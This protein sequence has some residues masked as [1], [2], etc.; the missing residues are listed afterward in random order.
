MIHVE[1]VRRDKGAE[2][3]EEAE[4]GNGLFQVVIVTYGKCLY[5]ISAD[6]IIAEKGD[7][8]LIPDNAFFYGKSIPTVT[9]DKYTA[10]FTLA[11]G[12]DRS[13]LPMLGAER[14]L[15]LKPHQISLMAQR[16]KE[17]H[18]RW[19]EPF[20]YREALC[21]GILLEMLALLQAEWDGRDR[22][23]AKSELAEL[24]KSYIHNHYREKVTKHEIGAFIGKSPNYA[25]SLFR[26]MTGQTIGDYVHTA[27]V[28]AAQSLLVES[29]MTVEDISE[30][31]G[32]ADV[33]YFY[34]IFKMKLGQV[35]S[36]YTKRREA[37][38]L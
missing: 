34:R 15:L 6:K 23:S 9:H 2:W 29:G 4:P 16:F 24:M 11:A 31:V 1:Y 33:S 27:R 35:P 38:K 26:E 10:G 18:E 30:Y 21:A 32:Y 8:L 3:F 13:L 5:R 20:A 36:D 17:M 22:K 7:V 12:A 14:V 37:R 19:G 25:A 28:K